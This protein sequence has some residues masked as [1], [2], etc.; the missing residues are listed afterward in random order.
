M[1]YLERF[2]PKKII[3]N[4]SDEELRGWALEQGGVITQAGNLAVIT[5]VRNRSAK[6]TEV[7]HGKQPGVEAEAL[8][9]KVFEYVKSCEMIQLDRVMCLHP[10]FRFKA[11]VYVT[12]GF[13]RIPLMWGNTLFKPEN[14][15]VDPDFVT[16]TI[17]EWEERRVLVFPEEGLTII[18]GTDYK[19]ENKKAMLRQLMYRVKQRGCLGLHA[20]S[21]IIRVDTEDGLRDQGFLF[22]GLSGTG[23][24]SLTCH[25]HWLNFPERVVIRQDDVVILL[26]DGQALGT[27]DSYYVK[28]DGLELDSQ[29]LLYAACLS[30]R[31]I[32]ENV[33]VLEDGRRIDFF[34][35]SLTSNGRAMVKRSDVAYT[36]ESIDV[37]Q[38]NNIVFITRRNDVVPPVTR[39]NPEWAAA[40]FM[41]GESIETSAGDPT[42]AGRSIRVVGTNPFIVGSE[43]QEGN[44]FL[45]IL[46]KNPNIQCYNMNTGMF[47]GTEKITVKDSV[48]IIEMIARGQI[49]WK[50]DEY[51]GYEV[52]EEIP[53]IDLE[54]FDLKNYYEPSISEALSQALRD[55][56][57]EW[58]ERF[59]DLD[60]S[61]IDAIRGR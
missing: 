24:T 52:P 56:R 31:A 7:F 5:K 34:D 30:P 55:D 47:G 2:R 13:P 53:G 46:R 54:R 35:T 50:Q 38:V 43:A 14:G 23:K 48:R 32:L 41:L 42:M 61:I 49:R 6:F 44:I 8:L 3:D 20:G 25:S 60:P 9:D 39:L 26:P 18:L 37:G 40:A 12:S 10:D 19:G 21:K 1:D 15:N 11:R 59:E 28:T 57:V 17:P 16:I 22:F 51:W 4:P 45:D 33:M 36:D 58:L 27:E 29:P